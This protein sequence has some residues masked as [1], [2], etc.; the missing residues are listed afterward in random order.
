MDQISYRCFGKNEM[1]DEVIDIIKLVCLC[2]SYLEISATF[3][4][5]LL[6]I[7]HSFPPLFQEKSVTSI[8]KKF[9]MCHVINRE[10]P[11]F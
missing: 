10:V 9:L 8:Q 6:C 7:V 4:S 3:L 2:S 1:C 5:V 11:S